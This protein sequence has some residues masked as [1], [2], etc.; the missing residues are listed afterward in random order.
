MD[1]FQNECSKYRNQTA[2]TSTIEKAFDSDFPFFIVPSDVGGKADYEL[3]IYKHLVVYMTSGLEV[4]CV[5][6]PFVYK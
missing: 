5:L 1:I 4:N 6:F 2:A 3:N